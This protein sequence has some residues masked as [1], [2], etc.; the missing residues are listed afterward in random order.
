MAGIGVVS[1]C[2]KEPACCVD[3]FGMLGSLLASGCILHLSCV[4]AAAH[5]VREPPAPIL[6]APKLVHKL[7]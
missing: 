6:D 3:E 1:G 5:A 7:E 4:R 2:V